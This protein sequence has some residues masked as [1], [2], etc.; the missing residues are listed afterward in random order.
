VQYRFADF[1][2]DEEV[3][4]LRRGDVDVPLRRQ[5]LDVLLLLVSEAPRVVSR[6]ELIDRV[7]KGSRVTDNAVTQC[8]REIRRALGERGHESSLVQ[9]VHGRGFRLNV[10][11]TRERSCF[12]TRPPPAERGLVISVAVCP[13]GGLTAH[14]PEEAIGRRISESL[15]LAL[16]RLGTIPVVAPRSAGRAAQEPALGFRLEGNVYQTG[17]RVGVSVRLA[18]TR[19]ETALWARQFEQC[20]DHSLA[21]EDEL[22]AA[23]CSAIHPEIVRFSAARVGTDATE[24][25]DPRLLVVRGLEHYYRR[26]P[27][28]NQLAISYLSRAVEADPA[29][30]SAPYYLGLA[31]CNNV[32]YQWHDNWQESLSLAREAADRAR[33]GSPGQASSHILDALLHLFAGDGDSARVSAELAVEANPN[34]A[35][36]RALLGRVL[37]VLGCGDAAIDEVTRAMKLSPG[38]PW[39]GDLV[40]ARAIGE[41]AAERYDAAIRYAQRAVH[42]APYHL[43]SHLVMAASRALTGDMPGASRVAHNVRSLPRVSTAPLRRILS[44]SPAGLTDRFFTGISLA[45]LGDSP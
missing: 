8:V 9:T 38:D 14:G 27:A 41:F 44:A 12:Q 23:V 34:M 15:T 18:D 5:A 21:A 42:Y 3:Y 10:E 37:A 16:I 28:D 33:Q 29:C 4:R 25:L 22:A 17:A 39:P 19:T 40:S 7:W 32:Y 43:T 45:G 26:T 1:V 31:H 2:I 6:A 13:F 11:V 35:E 24:S 30:A 20:G 36:T